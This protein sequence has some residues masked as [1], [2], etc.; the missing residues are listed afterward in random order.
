MLKGRS[1]PTEIGLALRLIVHGLQNLY[2]GLLLKNAWFVDFIWP[3][4]YDWGQS[5]VNIGSAD[6]EAR[7]LSRK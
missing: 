3:L 7:Q 4:G 5:V 6:N 1:R 2:E